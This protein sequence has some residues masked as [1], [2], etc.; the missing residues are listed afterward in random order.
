LATRLGA[1]GLLRELSFSIPWTQVDVADATGMT[2]IHAN[3]IIQDLRSRGL[4]Q[5]EGKHVKIIRWEQL[6]Q[7]A[8]FSA[9]YLHLKRV[10]PILQ[11]LNLLR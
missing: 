7:V 11:Q 1:V 6:V 10:S 2:D 8:G 9:D 4:V 3:R 5:W